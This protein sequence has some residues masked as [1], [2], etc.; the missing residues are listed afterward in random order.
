MMGSDN[1]R[2]G[3]AR[4]RVWSESCLHCRVVDRFGTLTATVAAATAAST[5]TRA[6]SSFQ[7]IDL[8]STDPIHR[9][10]TY[11][12]SQHRIAHLEQRWRTNGILPLQE[13]R[14]TVPLRRRLAAKNLAPMILINTSTNTNTNSTASSTSSTNT[15]STNSTSSTNTNHH[16]QQHGASS[17]T[18]AAAAAAAPPPQRHP[19]QQQQQQQVAPHAARAY[20]ASDEAAIAAM[21]APGPS[22]IQ[23]LREHLERSPT[24]DSWALTL[25]KQVES[26]YR[27]LKAEN[28][29][30]RTELESM[31]EPDNL[32]PLGRRFS[33]LARGT[34]AASGS[35]DDGP[36]A[37]R[38]RVPGF[39]RAHRLAAHQFVHGAAA[40]HGDVLNVE[41]GNHAA[42]AGDDESPPPPPPQQQQPSEQQQQQQLDDE[43]AEP[44]EKEDAEVAAITNN[45]RTSNPMALDPFGQQQ[46]Q[47]SSAA[48]S[49]ESS[50]RAPLP[51]SQQQQALAPS[52]PFGTYGMKVVADG[53]G[54]GG[55]NLGEHGTT[56]EEAAAPRHFQ[57]VLAP[58]SHNEET[59]QGR[60]IRFPPQNVNMSFGEIRYETIMGQNEDGPERA[61][62]EEEGA[63]ENQE[64]QEESRGNDEAD[65]AA[66]ASNEDESSCFEWKIIPRPSADHPVITL[67]GKISD[68]ICSAAGEILIKKMVKN[69][70]AGIREIRSKRF[71]VYFEADDGST[72]AIDRIFNAVLHRYQAALAQYTTAAQAR[73]AI[74]GYVKEQ[75]GKPA[76]FL[77]GNFSLV[78]S[79]GASAAQSKLTDVSPPSV[80]VGLALTDKVPATLV[81]KTSPRITTAKEF[82]SAVCPK[83]TPAIVKIWE[84]NQDCCT[85]FQN[86]GNVLHPEP[87]LVEGQMMRTGDVS[88]MGSNTVHGG[89]SVASIS[90]R[91]VLLRT[92]KIRH[93][94][95]P[96]GALSSRCVVHQHFAAGHH[97]CGRV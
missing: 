5:S 44:V 56:E 64:E 67:L 33:V 38:I 34:A 45:N 37:R 89:S 73:T 4:A 57:P 72:A 20:S 85:L 24:P 71:E 54:A 75:S 25:L 19:Q 30:L 3:T 95:Q 50:E 15:N 90:G 76:H 2:I 70:V 8:L 28:R 11:P 13:T 1:T 22:F 66:E 14:P 87:S 60:S 84:A 94:W 47:P 42:A 81:Y 74:V 49:L 51:P 69:S 58:D 17:S 65:E 23:M 36:A 43:D 46:Q 92:P 41:E 29:I 12:S 97:H 18:A 61:A 88:T 21:L 68:F 62:Q 35:N 80:Q 32:I 31:E 27:A 10:S 63:T 7:C 91:L 16:H 53:G 93:A 79:L 26:Q 48:P 6:A 78:I 86:Y 77:F 52:P 39:S 83:L 96:S 55:G 9:T 82:K 40:D 59:N